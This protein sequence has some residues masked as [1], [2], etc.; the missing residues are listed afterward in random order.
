[1]TNKFYKENH[2]NKHYLLRMWTEIIMA[3]SSFLTLIITI[4][5]AKGIVPS[6]FIYIPIGFLGISVVV[7]LWNPIATYIRRKLQC[8]RY[9]QLSRYCFPDF[10]ELTRRFGEFVD[11]R[12]SDNLSNQIY[13]LQG[14]NEVR[15][16]L[17][18]LPLALIESFFYVFEKRLEEFNREFESLRQ[19][20]QEFDVIMRF[21]NRSYITEPLQVIRQINTE[22]ISKE[23]ADGIELFR[24]NYCAFLRDYINYAK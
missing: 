19:L 2:S 6:W 10:K 13:D 9:K 15:G 3:I 5:T 12:I 21:Y 18:L 8:K 7:L 24:E 17:T 11:S 16:K 4:V 14:Y 20:A 23:K 1:M 22:I